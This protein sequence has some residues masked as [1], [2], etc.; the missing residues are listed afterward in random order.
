MLEER[1]SGAILLLFLITIR[2]LGRTGSLLF[3]PELES[4]PEGVSRQEVAPQDSFVCPCRRL[5]LGDMRWVSIN[6]FLCAF[7]HKMCGQQEIQSESVVCLLGL[8]FVYYRTFGL[9]CNIFLRRDSSY[10]P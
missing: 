9:A 6:P 4:K 2:G 7:V 1:C 8:M 5:L 10:K 3:I